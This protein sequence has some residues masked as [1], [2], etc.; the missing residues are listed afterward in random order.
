MKLPRF[1]ASTV[2][3]G[4]GLARAQDISSLTRTGEQAVWQSVADLGQAGMKTGNLA[5]DAYIKRQALDDEIEFGEATKRTVEIF[6]E[7]AYEA[8]KTDVTMDMPDPDDP[9]YMN[10]LT[11]F[12]ATKRDKLLQ[13]ALKDIEDN[14]TR[15]NRGFKGKRAKARFERWYNANYAD[16]T[17]E[18]RK[19]YDKKLDSYQRTQLTSLA[20]AAASNGDME[21][22]EYY[23]AIMDKYELV[24]PERAQQ[25]I[26]NI[27]AE[28][29]KIIEEQAITTLENDMVNIAA[30]T[31]WDI[32]IAFLADPANLEILTGAGM[33]LDE[34]KKVLNNMKAFANTQK[35][36]QEQQIEEL[37]ENNTKDF[38]LKIADSRAPEVE[39]KTPPTPS[40]ILAAFRAGGITESQF[41]NLNKRLAKPEIVTD[42]VIQSKLYTKSLDIWRGAVTKAEFDAELN[43][44]SL[45]LDDDDYKALAKSAADTLRSSQAEALSR[46]DTE[47]GRLIVDYREEDAFKKFISDSLKGL[48][49]DAASLFQD[50]ANKIRKLQFWYLSKYNQE[51]RQWITDNP[52]KVGKDF[53]QYSEQLKHQYW[54]TSRADIEAK[55][56]VREAGFG[57]P[58]KPKEV[59]MISSE[60]KRYRV[61][62]KKKQV[63][64]DNGFTEE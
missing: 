44:N 42:R 33:G 26:K 63:F 24:T 62:I 57:K 61:P 13:D 27:K 2:P 39:G 50:E 54:N 45:K 53:F 30:S 25:L 37:Q 10:T 60:G 8:E 11:S 56:L 28:G 58:E 59:I 14:A 49:P 32:A 3:R 1:T 34:A 17:D 21:T 31:N 6:R 20:E 23:V 22:A 48:S 5:A 52:D 40:E 4:S 55:K 18:V 7:K 12:S 15:L 29:Q 43:K 35:D 64:I 16:F 36:L 19:I 38:I 9:D 51:L 47:A 46:A 41:D